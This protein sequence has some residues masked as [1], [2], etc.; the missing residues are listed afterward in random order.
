MDAADPLRCKRAEFH[1]P[2]GVIY[3]DGNSLGLLPVS[4]K[5]RVAETVENEWGNSLIRAWNSHSWMDL[6]EK[7]GAKIAKLIG[8][9][10]GTVV[11]VDT[12]SLNVAKA[13]SAAMALNP[14]RK[15]ILTD[16]GNFPTDIYMAQGI[17]DLVDK[18]HEVRIVNP[19]DVYEALDETI[20]VMMITQVDYRTGRRHNMKQL[21]ERAHAVGAITVWD[22]AHSAGAFEVDLTSCNVDLAV[23]CT[24]KYFNGGPGAPAFI[25]VA[26]RHQDNI[27]PILSGWIGH[28]APFAFELGYQPA[29]GIKRM[30]VGTPPV[31]ALSALDAALDVWVDV[32]MSEV[33]MKS[34]ALSE[35][36]IAEV[37]SR[38]TQF[39]LTLASPRDADS[40]GSQV[41]FRCPDGYA[42]MQALI[43]EGIIGDFRAPD[44]I[45]FGFTP[46]YLG[47]EDVLNAT[48][49]LEEILR[50]EVWREPAFMKR[51]KVT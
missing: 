28:K 44:I 27:K 10:E 38:C 43:A 33:R 14:E 39:G 15:V 50:S 31:I 41:S 8:A 26:P 4:V 29:E 11:S 20:A 5:D 35:L 17:A 2:E 40:R 49:K 13:V 30:N 3:L 16:N 18:G 47:Y 12:T 37:E 46:L 32:D 51:E 1:V 42:V 48:K 34:V 21:T 9:E 23:G 6:P 45:R 25:Y 24:Y 36:F 7:V 19:Q 22:L